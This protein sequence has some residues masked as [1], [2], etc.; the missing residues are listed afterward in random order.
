MNEQT[1]CKIAKVASHAEFSHSVSAVY[2]VS[3]VSEFLQSIQRPWVSLDPTWAKV[4]SVQWKWS[5]ASL[6]DKTGY[7]SAQ[8]FQWHIIFYAHAVAHGL[9]S[10]PCI[11]AYAKYLGQASQLRNVLDI[12]T[13]LVMRWMR[14]YASKVLQ[15]LSLADTG[16]ANELTDKT[17][18]RL[19]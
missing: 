12:L 14:V 3:L 13:S 17:A 18:I 1:T 8:L 2:I 15:R 11:C 6:Y 9:S 4:G 19:R 10:P 7:Y 5:R 16:S